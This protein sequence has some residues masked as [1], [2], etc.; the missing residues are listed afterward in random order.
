MTGP[1]AVSFQREEVVAT[2]YVV[3]GGNNTTNAAEGR[4]RGEDQGY[5]SHIVFDEAVGMQGGGEGVMEEGEVAWN[6]RCGGL[7]RIRGYA[8]HLSQIRCCL[9]SFFCVQLD[10]RR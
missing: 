6:A 8:G 10:I 4:E 1:V 7:F 9:V 2:I 3:R 5:P